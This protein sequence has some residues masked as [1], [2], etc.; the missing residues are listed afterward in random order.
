[1]RECDLR[2]SRRFE[3]KK[4]LN[5]YLFDANECLGINC[6]GYDVSRRGLG[7]VSLT[8]MTPD[9]H[10]VFIF[11]NLNH[12]IRLSVTHCTQIPDR[13]NK[14]YHIGFQTCCSHDDLL[15]C[16]SLEGLFSGGHQE[17]GS[18]EDRDI[19]L[20]YQDY[21][22]I[23]SLLNF[24]DYEILDRIGLKK[25][26]RSHDAYPVNFRGQ[27]LVAII[28]RGWTEAKITALSEHIA[29][30]QVT[31]VARVKKNDVLDW[32]R[33]WPTNKEVEHLAPLKWDEEFDVEMSS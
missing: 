20:R 32:V 10:V 5:N 2:R 9:E 24:K 3:F 19:G 14:I 31:I 15:H 22:I 11:T 12:R 13:D 18:H 26:T 21:K 28:P 29:M 7:V 25:L 30:Q 1:M 8:P 6:Y 33:V 23:A 4:S 17:G 16:L 27:Q